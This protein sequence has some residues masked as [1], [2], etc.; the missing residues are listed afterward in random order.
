MTV[1]SPFAF[2]LLHGTKHSSGNS[3]RI[4]AWFEGDGRRIADTRDKRVEMLKDW[5]ARSYLTREDAAKL[6]EGR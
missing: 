5:V 4:A 3:Q 6:M 1:A 2:V